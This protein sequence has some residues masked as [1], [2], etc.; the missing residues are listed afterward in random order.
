M[1]FLCKKGYDD[2]QQAIE[3]MRKVF[4]KSY[5]KHKEQLSKSWGQEQDADG[6][7]TA[8]LLTT[9]TRTA[10]VSGHTS[11]TNIPLRFWSCRES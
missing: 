5:E 2:H 7:D 6:N 11:Y 1:H 10:S 3:T 8:Q 9:S 4:S